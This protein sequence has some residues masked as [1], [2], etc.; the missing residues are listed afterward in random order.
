[1][2]GAEAG[3]SDAAF[4]AVLEKVRSAV[5]RIQ[6]KVR[7][8]FQT[9]HDVISSI[10]DILLP[11]G[12]VQKANKLLDRVQRLAEKFI[13]KI[14]EY[15]TSPGLPSALRATGHQWSANVGGTVRATGD[16]ISTAKMKV[17][18]YW[19]GNGAMAYRAT[20]DR[21]VPACDAMSQLTRDIDEW[22]GNAA[23]AIE[24]F[25]QAVS[26]AAIAL[27]AGV[28]T[29]IGACAT[30]VGAPGG[31]IALIAGILTAIGAVAGGYNS[32]ENQYNDVVN[33]INR[34]KAEATQN[35]TFSQ[36]WPAASATGTWQAD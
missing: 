16:E 15:L 9:V 5:E 36:G 4:Q 12:L 27:A 33:A 25:W 13:Q 14:R 8:L 22:L 3:M 23:A 7:E 28:V 18:D 29:C 30:G 32:A 1:M 21:Q 26:L 35:A 17:D 20:L 24:E 6:R 31:L 10:P 2:S 11:D 19:R 34:M